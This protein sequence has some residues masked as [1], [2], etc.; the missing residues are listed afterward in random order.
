[1]NRAAYSYIRFSH[2]AQAAGRSQARQIE[3]CEEYCTRHGLTLAQ[4]DDYRFLDAGVSGWKGDH[5]GEKG[6]L[7]RFRKLVDDGTVERGST[8]IIESLDRINRQDVWTALPWFMGLIRAGVNVV[9]LSDGRVYTDKGGTEDLI[10]SIFSMSRAH[11]ESTIKSKRVRD[12]YAKKHELARTENKPMGNAKPMWLELSDDKKQYILRPDRAA[13]V[14]RIYQLAIDGYGK[15]ASSKKLNIEGIPSFKGKTWGASSLDKV[16]NN[17]AVL[18]EYQPY[19]VQ[20]DESGVRQKS[21][22]PIL[23]YYP[24]AIDESTFYQAKAAIE[25]RRK[26]GTTNQSKNFNVWQGVAK[27]AL[28]GGTTAGAMHLVNKGKAPK[29]NTYLQCYDARKGMC[30]GK[31]VRL[32]SSELVFKEILFLLDSKSLIQDDSIRISKEITVVVSKIDQFETQLAEFKALLIESRSRTVAGL[33]VSTEQDITEL[34]KQLIVLQTSLAA[35]K[36]ISKQDFRK[37]LDLKTYEGRNRANTLLKNMGVKVHIG[38]GY[39]VTRTVQHRVDAILA[40]AH[41]NGEVSHRFLDEDGEYTEY[42]E[43]TCSLDAGAAGLLNSLKKK[44]LSGFRPNE[45]SFDY[46]T[47]KS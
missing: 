37:L 46:K 47:L 43:Y 41:H 5:L 14:Q 36:S 15:G 7:A 18:G 12:A 31:V 1:M 20:V 29:G 19:S 16:L 21:G 45:Q 9:T 34:E 28:C 39:I 11:E 35:E 2:P 40:L 42:T 10:L 22:D 4:G 6:Q 8:L 17:R 3:A 30:K 24:A 27:C 25:G 26:A 13:L 33:I 44:H 38:E 23:N 32:D